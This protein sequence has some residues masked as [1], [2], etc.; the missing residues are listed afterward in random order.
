[1]V[2]CVVAIPPGGEC[3]HS[4]TDLC[5]PTSQRRAAL[6]KHY[7]FVCDCS[8]CER[9][10]TSRRTSE[11]ASAE[12]VQ[13]INVDE[14]LSATRSSTQDAAARASKDK[15]EETA[16]LKEAAHLEAAAAQYQA[17]DDTENEQASLAR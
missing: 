16:A 14:A 13:D 2:R 3:C 9:G 6:E 15:Q 12:G 7:G 11:N 4:Y 8:R 17:T 5:A 10:L 1:M